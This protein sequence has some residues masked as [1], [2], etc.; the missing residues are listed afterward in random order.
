MRGMTADS[1]SAVLY[2]EA[3]FA[4]VCSGN[5]EKL[6]LVGLG[7]Q[8]LTELLTHDMRIGDPL[9]HEIDKLTPDHVAQSP[10][11]AY[12]IVARDRET[13]AGRGCDDCDGQVGV[14]GVDCQRESACCSGI[15]MTTRALAIAGLIVGLLAVMLGLVALIV[16][17]SD[18]SGTRVPSPVT[19]P[20]STPVLTPVPRP[21]RVFDAGAVE[22]R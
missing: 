4:M 6:L 7:A 13:T 17:R 9:Q 14:V 2:R 10:G 1:F 20:V 16:A 15:V 3:T 21:V 12:K 8:L 11:S 18:G 22:F 19:T 5:A